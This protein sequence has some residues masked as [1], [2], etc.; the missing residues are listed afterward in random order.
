MAVQ[1]NKTKN[2]EEPQITKYQIFTPMRV[3]RSEL[4]EAAYNPRLITKENRKKLKQSVKEGLADA[5]VWNKRTGNV[6]GG[7]QRLSVLDELERNKNYEMDVLAIDVDESTEKKLNIKLNNPNMQGEYDLRGLA[8]LMIGDNISIQEVGFNQA[9]AEVMFNETELAMLSGYEQ[10]A[11]VKEDI[12]KIKQMKEMRKTAMQRY[13]QLESTEYY[14]ILVFDSPENLQKFVEH[15]K[16]NEKERYISGEE[17]AEKLGLDLPMRMK[18]DWGVDMGQV[19][20][21]GE[22]QNSDM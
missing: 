4:H 16:L 22:N 12:E 2:D 13:K 21:S 20:G 3:N 15:F 5:I 10:P 8:E 6:V 7:H 19:P 17:V 1:K 11:E 9:D 14:K 18:D